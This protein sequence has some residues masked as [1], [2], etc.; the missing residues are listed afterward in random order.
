MIGALLLFL[1][2]AT[3]DSTAAAVLLSLAVGFASFCEGPF[4]A[5]ATSIGG[6]RAGAACGIMNA[7]GN[8]GGFFSPV[9]TP[10]VAKYFGWSWGLYTGSIMIVLGALACWFVDTSEEMPPV[11]NSLTSDTPV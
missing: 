4:W 1:G 2:V 8:I 9:L 3:S 11:T 5:M 6:L 10:L 7:G